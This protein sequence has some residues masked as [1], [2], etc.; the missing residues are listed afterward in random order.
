MVEFNRIIDP[1][2]SDP[3]PDLAESVVKSG[4]VE[5]LL[6]L[7]DTTNQIFL[8]MVRFNFL[9]FSFYVQLDLTLLLC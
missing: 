3:V 2:I 7:P 8:S 4:G 1:T 6:S 9:K 5:A